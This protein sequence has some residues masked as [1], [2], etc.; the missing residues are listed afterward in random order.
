M[1]LIGKLTKQLSDVAQ[2]LSKSVSG[3]N[4]AISAFQKKL[5]LLIGKLTIVIHSGWFPGIAEHSTVISLDALYLGETP[6]VYHQSPHWQHSITIPVCGQYEYLD[7]RTTSKEYG[8]IGS[9]QIPIS[10]ISVGKVT[11]WRDYTP[12]NGG[13]AGKLNITVFYEPANTWEVP[14]Q[15]FVMRTGCFM[16]LYQGAHIDEQDSPPPIYQT[17]EGPPYVAQGAFRDMYYAMYNAKKFLYIT[18]WSVNTDTVLLRRRMP[19]PPG[20]QEVPI[21]SVGELLKYKQGQGVCVLVMVWDDMSSTNIGGMSVGGVMSTHDEETRAFCNKNGIPVALVHREGSQ[22]NVE[23][24]FSHHQKTIICDEA[25][26]GD[27]WQR[28]RIVAFLGGL[29]ITDGRWDTPKKSLFSTLSS[30]H[31]N[32]FYNAWGGI[33]PQLGPRQPWQDAHCKVC[34]PIARDVMTNF[35]QRWKKQA[36][37]KGTL[38]SLKE[39]RSILAYVE[40]RFE[41]AESWNVQL[42]RSIDSYSATISAVEANIHW[43]YVNAI[44]KS[45]RFLYIENQYFLGSAP[46]WLDTTDHNISCNNLIPVEIVSKIIHMINTQREYTVYIVIPLHPEG[47]PN[48]AAIQAILRWQ[49]N[50]IEMMYRMLSDALERV[51]SNRHPREYL[52]FLTLGNREAPPPHPPK[53]TGT[54]LRQMALLKSR[55]FM[56]YVHTKMLIADDEFILLGSANINERSLHG[57]RDTE[58]AVGAYQPFHSGRS[59]EVSG[60]IHKFRMSLWAEHLGISEQC[61]LYPEDRVTVTRVN[62]IADFNWDKFA[63]PEVKVMDTGHMMTYP[64][65]VEINGAIS[66]A[67][68]FFPDTKA[69]IRGCKSTML[70]DALTT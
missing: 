12:M 50:T 14:D 17:L 23:L 44:R 2:T 21:L 25:V 47:H 61:F 46:W 48:E 13:A 4:T 20:L 70:P 10:E 66:A 26:A 65:K 68:Q 53:A 8:I 39:E 64:I 28:R 52:T 7:L 9:V 34:G 15:P 55:R 62:Q 54:T 43:A 49:W 59:R 16:Q 51:G 22:P 60:E 32:D 42:F 45:E 37:N 40:D 58:I 63:S 36:K 18:G 57:S 69:P 33:N 38:Y 29:D 24:F 1:K 30:D 31:S 3:S 67:L 56:V 41:Y 6:Y 27:S 5:S 11:G 35:E 19:P